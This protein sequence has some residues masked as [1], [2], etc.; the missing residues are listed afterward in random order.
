MAI[1]SECAA[2]RMPTENYLSSPVQY[3]VNQRILYDR[4]S[5]YINMRDDGP[6]QEICRVR[7]K[8]DGIWAAGT[9]FHYPCAKSSRQMLHHP[10]EYEVRF[11]QDV[12]FPDTRLRRRLVH[13][14]KRT[15]A[16]CQ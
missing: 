15:V 13:R 16:S 6:D 5:C 11:I 10:L 12:E 1:T 8:Y 4:S 7:G 9:M 3:T 2:Q 14:E